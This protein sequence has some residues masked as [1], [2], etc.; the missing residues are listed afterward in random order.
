MDVK[1]HVALIKSNRN[2]RSQQVIM[3]VEKKKDLSSVRQRSIR[4]ARGSRGAP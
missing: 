2:M 1:A 4:A 3:R